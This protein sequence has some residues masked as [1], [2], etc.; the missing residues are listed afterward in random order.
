MLVD[1]KARLDQR[2]IY[3]LLEMSVFPDPDRIIEVIENYKREEAWRLKGYE[4]AGEII[5]LAGYTVD[6][7]GRLTI[8]HLAVDPDERG[9]GY[10]RG[11]VLHLLAEEKPATI[12]A[13]TDE[14][15]VGFYRSIGFAVHSVGERYPGVERY[16]C[17]YVADPEQEEEA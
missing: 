12:E 14:E 3:E 9:K 13:E 6:G 11:I 15:G 16:R 8:R 10:G 4:D 7:D 5:G 17:L 1:V 2:P